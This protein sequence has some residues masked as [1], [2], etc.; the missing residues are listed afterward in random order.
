VLCLPPECRSTG[1][2]AAQQARKLRTAL[3]AGDGVSRTAY[4]D[5]KVGSTELFQGQERQVIIISTV[6]S[7]RQFVA[8]HDVK[9]N[10]GFLVMFSSA[11]IVYVQQCSLESPTRLVLS[12][13]GEPQA[14]QRRRHARDGSAVRVARPV[15]CLIRH[16]HGRS[17]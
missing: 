10:I 3:S 12:H 8:E 11:S 17:D 14:F 6:R 15:I 7:T 9:H 2:P 1:F 13:A 4:R 5:I 16:S